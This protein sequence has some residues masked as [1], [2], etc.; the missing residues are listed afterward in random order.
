MLT[1]D[2]FGMATMYC[3]TAS[4]S[5]GTTCIFLTCASIWLQALAYQWLGRWYEEID[6]DY[7]QAQHCYERA[8][9]LDDDDIIASKPV[10]RLCCRFALRLCCRFAR[11]C[12]KTMVTSNHSVPDKGLSA[13]LSDP[14]APALKNCWCDGILPQSWP[15][16]PVRSSRPWHGR[17]SVQA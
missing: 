5:R 3:W 9:A 7:K 14:S 11:Q 16:G 6:Q 17:F 13:A 8:V 12:F 1:L 15:Y 4:A 2:T 10:L